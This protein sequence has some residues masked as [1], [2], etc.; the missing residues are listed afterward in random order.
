MGRTKGRGTARYALW[1]GDRC[2]GIGTA[3]ELAERLGCKPETIRW[4]ATPAAKKRDKGN[5]LVAER[6]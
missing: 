5:R 2:L 1:K 4:H 3:Y 6:I